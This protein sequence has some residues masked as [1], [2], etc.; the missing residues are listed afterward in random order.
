MIQGQNLSYAYPSGQR[1]EFPDFKFEQGSQWLILGPSGS[2]KTTLLQL[3]AGLRKPA[4]GLLKM[5]DKRL[6][7]MNNRTLD[8]YRGAQ[9]GI[10]FQ[11]PHFVASL[12]I[13]DNLLLA[14]YLAGKK[15]D[16][17]ACK[18]VLSALG[19]A[20]KWQRKPSELSQ[21]ERQR[22]SL[23][24]ALCKGPSVLLA[25]EP[26]SALDDGNTERVVELMKS[27]A[28]KAGAT[29]ILVTHDQRLKDNFSQK[30]ELS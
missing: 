4:G 3:L 25:D 2:G 6:D 29:L 22:V 10:V 8:E 17:T 24:R 13:G 26:S 12:S 9:I 7:Q 21:G 19:L 18:E 11:K 20:D 1:I 28:K 16:A 23:A 15:Q 5:N 14:Q 30:I 27:Q